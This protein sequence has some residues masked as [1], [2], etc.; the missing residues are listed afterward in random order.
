M[1]I[2]LQIMDQIGDLIVQLIEKNNDLINDY[3]ITAS[4]CN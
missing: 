2:I 4:Q 3:F 1:R